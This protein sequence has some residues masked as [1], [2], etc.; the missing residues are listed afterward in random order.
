MSHFFTKQKEDCEREKKKKYKSVF[1][2]N[3]SFSPVVLA[4]MPFVLR[5]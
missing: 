3:D 4:G 5:D 1:G 2:G